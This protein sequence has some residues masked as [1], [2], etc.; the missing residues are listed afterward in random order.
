M[1]KRIAS[2][3]P[4][5]VAAFLMVA[6]LAVAQQKTT[7]NVISA[8]D[9]NMVDYIKDYLGHSRQGVTARY[10]SS[11]EYEAVGADNMKLFADYLRRADTDARVEHV[12]TLNLAQEVAARYADDPGGLVRLIEELLAKLN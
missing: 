6:S 11:I 3:L 9:V 10:T 5:S 12:E 7:L 2:V 1:M 4:L 8:G